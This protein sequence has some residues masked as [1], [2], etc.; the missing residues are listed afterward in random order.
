MDVKQINAA[1]LAGDFSMDELRSIW[2]TVKLANQRASLMKARN[3]VVGDK[4]R[5]TGR[6]GRRYEGTVTKIAMKN[7]VVATTAGSY[8]VPANMLEAA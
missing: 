7:L 3:F 1:I 8:R 2:D 4:V 6:G 5:F